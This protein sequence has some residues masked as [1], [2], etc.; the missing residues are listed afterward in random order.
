[1]I[2]AIQSETR[3]AVLSMEEGVKEVERGTGDAAKSGVALESIL[4]Q[5]NEVAT[6]IN[7][8]ATAAEEQTA[9]TTEITSYIQRITRGGAVQRQ[10]LPRIGH[11]GQ[12]AYDHI[13]G[14]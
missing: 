6:Q 10:K 13:N 9:T 2:R 12:P 11:R 14:T 4:N 1:M 7:Q 5:I 8:I 3:G